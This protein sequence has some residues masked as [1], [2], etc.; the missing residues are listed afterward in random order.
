MKWSLQG[1][2]I[3]GGF[4]LTLLLT[5]LASW[6]SYKNIAAIT[7]SA[8]RVQYTCKILNTLTDF[9]ATMSVAESGRRGYIYSGSQ[10][11]LERHQQ[12][13]DQM[14]TDLK[15]LQQQVSKSPL[16]QQRWERLNSLVA[17]RLIL[18]QQSIQI[19][20]S[21]GGSTQIQNQITERSVNIRGEIQAILGDMKAEE[22]Q[23]LKM[24][25]GQ[26][27]S[28]IVS[29]ILIE[30][31]GSLLSF[32]VIFGVYF[33]LYYQWKQRQKLEVLQQNLEQQKEL[34]DL[35]LRLFSM[36]SHEF[37]TPLSVIIASSQ[38]L[39][40][41]LQGLVEDC[42]LKNLYRIQSSAKLMNQLLTDILTLT[43]AEA[44]KLEFRP[45]SIDV[46]AFC[47]NLLEDIQFCSRLNPNINFISQGHCYRLYCDEKLLYSML[48]NLLLNAIKYSSSSEKV[49]H[50]ALRCES[51]ATIFQ[52]KD[53]GI[54]IPSEDLQAIYDPFYR[55]RN[56][57]NIVGTGLG[58]AVV[59]TCLE[60]H[61]GEIT[62][63]SQ[64]GVGTTFTLKIPHQLS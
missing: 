50:F 48:S 54:G 43:R 64:V 52:V 1:K 33:M 41:I 27:Q 11:E 29:R 45:S 25:V 47:L 19:Y 5:G 15:T 7:E 38:L 6:A 34:S 12:A 8:D 56:V 44:G 23:L 22:E 40:E 30:V 35:K 42:K 36:I 13:I 49:I 24:W 59:K 39:G 62:V 60:L 53:E 28:S 61:R 20:K 32:T 57:E 26:S 46:E 18:F 63:D 14:K 3:V 31:I 51:T 17:K 10:Q 21:H 16:Q 55:G 37:R 2:W 9:Y 4:F 58:L